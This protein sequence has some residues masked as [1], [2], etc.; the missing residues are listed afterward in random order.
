MVEKISVVVVDDHSLF[1][2]GVIQT[3]T[4]DPVL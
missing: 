1:R 3:L 4:L 2:A